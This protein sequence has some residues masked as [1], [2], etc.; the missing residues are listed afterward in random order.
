MAIKKIN[1]TENLGRTNNRA[2]SFI[3]SEA[4]QTVLDFP[5]K[6]VRAL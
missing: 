6:A 3:L 1:F 2:L 4:R 5:K